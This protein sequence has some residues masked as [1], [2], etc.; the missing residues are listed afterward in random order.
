M[1]TAVI[2]GS[3]LG[4]TDKQLECLCLLADGEWHDRIE[5][6]QKLGLK[7]INSNITIGLIRPLEEIEI[8]EQE[9]RPLKEG[10]KK[11]KK[12]IRIRQDVDEYAFCQTILNSARHLVAKYRKD[13]QKR[14]FYLGMVHAFQDR[15]KKLEADW[16]K[17][18]EEQEL[19]ELGPIVEGPYPS[20]WLEIQKIAKRIESHCKTQA[21]A[22]VAAMKAR[23]ELYKE[24]REQVHKMSRADARS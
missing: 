13:K 4:F 23:P 8:V 9:E 3:G 14:E 2:P 19:E 1:K 16:E 11:N 20:A 24:Y 21:D 7:L 5:I 12:V 17:E 15:I 10:S 22:Y 18:T 6:R